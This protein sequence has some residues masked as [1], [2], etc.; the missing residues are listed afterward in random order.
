MPKDNCVIETK[1]D[2]FGKW[3]A[4][5]ATALTAAVSAVPSY[6]LDVAVETEM[7]NSIAN[8]VAVG[9]LVMVAAATAFGIRWT[10]ATFF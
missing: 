6:A 9:G 10:K 8:M 2:K 5:G 3:V 1:K 4:V 7:T